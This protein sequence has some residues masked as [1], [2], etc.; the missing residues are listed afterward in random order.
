MSM[1]ELSDTRAPPGVR[2]SEC[3]RACV[4]QCLFVGVCVYV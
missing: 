3:E 1:Y 2:V 4:S